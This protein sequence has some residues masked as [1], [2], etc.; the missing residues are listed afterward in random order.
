MRLRELG[1][2][3][4]QRLGLRGVAKFDFKRAADG[5][6]FLLEVNPRFNL[7]H[8]PGALAGVNLPALVFRT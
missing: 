3:L 6:L 7:W 4:V 1:R 5:R 8:H 2:T